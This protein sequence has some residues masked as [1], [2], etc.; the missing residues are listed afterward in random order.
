MV[1]RFPTVLFCLLL[2]CLVNTASAQSPF[3]WVSLTNGIRFELPKNWKVIDPNT[4][5]TLEASVAARMPIKI[6]SNLPFAANLYNYQNQTIGMINVRT[7]PNR[8]VYQREVAQLTPSI[9]DAVNQQLQSSVSQGVASNGGR[10]TK[11]YGTEK[12]KIA[13]KLYLLSKYRRQS[14][15]NS[16]F[17]FRVSLLRLLDGS[18]SFTLTLSYEE[19][20]QHLLK[21]IINKIRN[22]IQLN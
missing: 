8:D 6:A 9:M 10:V 18:N 12:V 17:F 20:E 13:N 11:W 4:K 22:S 1:K 3:V 21:P 7:Y 19:K 15:I 16:N 2:L 14:S 5:T